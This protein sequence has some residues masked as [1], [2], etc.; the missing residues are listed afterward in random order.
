MLNMT[1]NKKITTQNS[2][3]TTVFGYSL[4]ALMVISFLA[5]TAIPFSFTLQHPTARHFNIV[6]MIVVFAISVILP[7][8]ASYFIA[9]KATHSKNKALHHYNG[10]LFG[11]TAYWV[12]MV[13]SWIGFYSIFGMSSPYP[14][15]LIVSNVSPVILTIIVMAIIATYYAK[16]QIN[17]TSVLQYKLFQIVLILS[18]VGAFLVPYI[19]GPADFNVI[20]GST[21]WLFVPIITI[22]I[23]YKVL[24]KYQ[25]T[26][27]ARLSDALIAMSLGWV[28]IWVVN[29]F[30]AY[31]QLPY[32]VAS[33]PGYIAGLAVFV[34]YLYLRTHK[35]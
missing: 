13:F 21:L 11:V 12:S 35:H 5:T 23:A 25:T 16:K 17:G 28:T 29:S 22:G 30:T 9:D 15:P 20:A 19:N 26:R 31:L 3:I 8:L 2:K 14:I 24:A 4:F 32:Q 6:V 27:L 1:K 7:A 18:V 34:T 33:I 10:V